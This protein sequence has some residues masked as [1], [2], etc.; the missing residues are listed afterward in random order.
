[1][2]TRGAFGV[3]IGEQEKIGYNQYDSYPD[4]RGLDNLRELKEAWINGGNSAETLRDLARKARLVSD[5]KKPTPEDVRLLR[6]TTNLNVSEQSTDDWYCLTR[7]TH[8]S[9]VQMLKC[10]YIEDHSTFPLD[11]LFCEWAY[12]L[13]LDRDVFEVYEGFNKTRP[14]GGRWKGRPTK[15][16][17][18]QALKDH[19]HWCHVNERDPWMTEKTISEFKA[20]ELAASWRLDGLPTDEEFIQELDPPAE[21]REQWKWSKWG[22]DA[23]KLRNARAARLRK[24]GYVVKCSTVDFTDLAREKVSVLEA[25]RA[26]RA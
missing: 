16:E 17:E 1:M 22:E 2:G 20:V 8:G 5:A 10:G 11:S 24:R 18:L 6:T 14:K 4:G 9:I 13:D 7:E 12:I 3:V 23:P 15:A 21:V 26:E 25:E 19:L